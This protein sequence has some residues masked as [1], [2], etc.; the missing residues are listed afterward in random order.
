MNVKKSDPNEVYHDSQL[1]YLWELNHPKDL[2]E[3]EVTT[4]E[5]R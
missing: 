2:E 3:K 5:V 1:V 4:K